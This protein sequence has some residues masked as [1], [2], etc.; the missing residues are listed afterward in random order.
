MK[1]L[2]IIQARLG[3]TRLP[4]KVLKEIGDKTLLDIHISRVLKSTKINQLLIATTTSDEDKSIVDNAE[5]N[6][7][8]YY[9]GSVSNVLDRF[10]QAAQMYRPQWIVRLT[11]DCPLIDPALIDGIIDCAIKNETDYC[12]N[13]LNPT[14]PDGMDVEVFKFSALE[15]AWNEAKLDSEKEHVTPYIYKNSTFNNKNIFSS[16]SYE[17]NENYSHVRLTVDELSDLETIKLLVDKLGIDKDWKTY[18][19][20]YSSEKKIHRLNSSIGRNEGYEKSLKT[21]I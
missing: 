15:K 11:A 10:Y 19:D 16:F 14:Y 12:S 2:A 1:V 6:K 8:P 7:L 3:S 21:D 17:N 20:Y 9:Q 18:T 4:G 13:T 5:K